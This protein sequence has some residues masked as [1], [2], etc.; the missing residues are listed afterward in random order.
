MRKLLFLGVF[1][2]PAAILAQAVPPGSPDQIRAELIEIERKIARAN[3][4]CDYKYLEQI[5]TDDFLFTDATG[6]T[7]AKK[8]RSSRR[9]ELSTEF[10]G[11]YDLDQSEVRVYGNAA[12]VTARVTIN[13][14]EPRGE[15]RASP[16]PLHGRLR[17][18]RRPV[19]DRRRTLVQNSGSE[20][21]FG[22][23]LPSAAFECVSPS[24]Q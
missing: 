23:R 16:Q 19:V 13:R 1:L 18:A 3:L 14:D 20:V 8:G 22:K 24:L 7:T 6:G 11:T 10:T 15:A 17:M 2:L 4:D 9:K 5:E 12:V 21:N